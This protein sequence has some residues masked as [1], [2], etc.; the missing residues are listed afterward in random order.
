[1]H[2]VLRHVSTGDSSRR[3]ENTNLH[4]SVHGVSASNSPLWSIDSSRNIVAHVS[5]TLP[6]RTVPG[7]VTSI[8]TDA[9]NDIGGEVALFGA[10]VLAMSNLTT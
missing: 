10:V 1:M 7:H 6:V 4:F 2:E 5:S 3:G 8:A 9:T